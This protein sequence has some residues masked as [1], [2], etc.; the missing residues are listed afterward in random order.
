MC[1]KRRPSDAHLLD[2]FSHE[3]DA[4]RCFMNSG[5]VPE[6]VFEQQGQWRNILSPVHHALL[7][8]EAHP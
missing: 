8:Q 4:C 1:R 2:D 3:V 7:Q 5:P 6:P